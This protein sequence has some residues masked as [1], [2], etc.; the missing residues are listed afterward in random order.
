MRHASEAHP[1]KHAPFRTSRVASHTYTRVCTPAT[2]HAPPQRPAAACSPAYVPRPSKRVYVCSPPPCQ[3]SVRAS[4]ACHLPQQAFPA[5]DAPRRW[6]VCSRHTR[7]WRLELLLPSRLGGQCSSHVPADAPV[8]VGA[9]GAAGGQHALHPSVTMHHIGGALH[10]MATLV[11]LV[12]VIFAHLAFAYMLGEHAQGSPLLLSS[13]PWKQEGT[14][15]V[16]T[17][18]S[19]ACL[20]AVPGGSVV[21]ISGCRPPALPVQGRTRH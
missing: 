1:S 3:H 12:G 18:E 17:L 11:G 7:A 14:K 2:A 9:R 10:P 21:Q 16:P 6:R 5:A 8:A 15:T 4:A 13:P 19:S 20:L